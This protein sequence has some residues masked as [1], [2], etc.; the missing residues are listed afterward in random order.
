MALKD[1][2]RAGIGQGLMMGWGDEAEAAL[3]SKITGRPYKEELSNIRKGIGEYSKK[4]PVLAPATEFVG[5]ALPVAASYLATVGSGGVATPTSVVTTAKAVGALN[6]LRQAMQSKSLA[7]AVG[8]GVATGA[9][10][11]AVSGAGSA[12]EGNKV[13]NA[14]IGAIVGGGLGAT[15]PLVARGMGAVKNWASERALPTAQ[16]IEDRA[17]GKL[18][19]AL[20]D[21]EISPSDITRIMAQDRVM[22]VPSRIANISRPTVSLT[23][24]VAQ[25]SGKSAERVAQALEDQMHGAKGRVYG[26]ARQEL[27]ARNYYE[28]EERLV[29]DLKKSAETLYNNAYAVGEV[30]DPTIMKMLD[31]PAYKKA[32][33]EAREL[34][35]SDAAVASVEGGDPNKFKLRELY[36]FV[37]DANGNITGIVQTGVVPDV[38]T[39]DYMKRALDKQVMTLGASSNAMERTL[40]GNVAKLRNALRE[41][42]KTIVPEYNE[43]LKK[44]AGDSDVIN[45]L[46]AGKDNFGTLGPEEVSKLFSGMSAAEQQAFRTGVVR[47]LYSK[48]MGPSTDFNPAKKLVGSTEF[49]AKLKPLFDSPAHFDMFEAA[50]KRED[51]LFRQANK[52][53]GGPATARRLQA[54]EVF[55]GNEETGKFVQDVVQGGFGKSLVNLAFRVANKATM[56]EKVADRVA[57]L[58]MSKSPSEVAAAVKLLEDY[59]VKASSAQKL[60]N[61]GESAVASGMS[62]AIHPPPPVA[63]TDMPTNLEAPPDTSG[64]KSLEDAIRE[65]E[66]SKNI[67]GNQ[68]Q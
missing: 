50:L 65:I 56:S 47:D 44:Y 43:A 64:T 1:I 3:R 29:K 19:K 12:E 37:T 60:I 57:Q 9:A 8:R 10:T 68:M 22:K 67:P 11:G 5:G 28:D 15:V 59:G 35:A 48:I 51:Q 27:H 21:A 45:A 13:K 23:E 32:F 52:I 41:Q 7:S 38:R 58:L 39:L 16:R 2:A 24:T 42:L 18:H 53:L 4:H 25:R 30:N 62:T 26:K 49:M 17:V 34:A 63:T 54:Q 31:M 46:R 61:A 14:K 33:A 40:G 55:D 66:K 6:K 36:N 20:T